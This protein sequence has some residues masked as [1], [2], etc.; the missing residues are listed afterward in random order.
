VRKKVFCEKSSTNLPAGAE[1]LTRAV[2]K[3]LQSSAAPAEPNLGCHAGF[4]YR[5]VTL[6]NGV[7][8]IVG[9]ASGCAMN[10]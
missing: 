2:E 4:F 1:N 10:S 5:T 8:G 3:T 9:S 6:A 7:F